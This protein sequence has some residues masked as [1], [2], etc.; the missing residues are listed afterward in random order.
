MIVWCAYS[1]GGGGGGGGPL[2]FFWKLLSFN[3]GPPLP[4]ISED[5]LSPEMR[6]CISLLSLRNIIRSCTELKLV[7][8]SRNTLPSVKH[9]TQCHSK[10]DVAFSIVLNCH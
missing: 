2:N 4:I 5:S 1:G 10:T 3:P 8:F 7:D 9:L 6:G